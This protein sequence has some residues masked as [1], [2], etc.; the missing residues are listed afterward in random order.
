MRRT[1]TA[2]LGLSLLLAACGQQVSPQRPAPEKLGA[3]ALPDNLVSGATYRLINEKSNLALDVAGGGT[4]EGTNV[5]IWTQNNLAP[6]NWKVEDSGNGYATLKS[7][8]S[9]MCL[10]LSGS[11]NAAGTNVQQWGC[12]GTNAQKWKLVGVGNGYYKLLSAVNNNLALD[13]AGG[14]TAAGTNV[15]VWTDNGLYPQHWKFER[16]DARITVY[17]DGNYG[18]ASQSFG[19]GTYRADAGQLS[20]VGNDQI[21]S[22]KVPSGLQARVC[23]NEGDGSGS[24]TCQTF[25]A[26]DYASISADLNDQISFIQVSAASGGGSGGGTNGVSAKMA[27]AFV[28]TIGM[29]THFN[30]ADTLWGKDRKA[31]SDKLGA[32]GVR[33]IR[34]ANTCYDFVVNTYKDLKDRFGIRLLTG[35]TVTTDPEGRDWIGNLDPGNTARLN[36]R[37]GQVKGCLNDYV[38]A[39]QGPNERAQDPRAREFARVLHDAVKADAAL[40]S[41]TLIGADQSDNGH[42]SNLGDISAYVDA[43]NI[44]AYP[45]ENP[46]KYMD[47]DRDAARTS[48]GS[49][50][51]SG[52]WVTE[53]G[54]HNAVKN[55]CPSPCWGHYGN[56][57]RASAKYAPRLF[58]EW[59]NRGAARV[60]WYE[61]LDDAVETG[62][63][64]QEPHFGWLRSDYSEKPVYGAMKRLTALLSD[65]GAAFTPGKLDYTLSGDTAGVHQTLLQ[66]RDGRFYLVLWQEVRS[67]EGWQWGDPVGKAGYDVEPSA[68]SVTVKFARPV[69]GNRFLPTFEDG[70]KETYS[71]TQQ[72]TVQVPDHVV[73]LELK[74]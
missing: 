56:S 3:Q 30:Y 48:Y 74:P 55:Q 70:V 66:K 64:N 10:D 25:G 49:L 16:M 36:E 72:I 57:E 52:Y 26:G 34:D 1:I 68:K 61:F 51:N 21:S 29:N 9:G 63:T 45:V 50:M 38:E 6:Q 31:L 32:A 73:V 28:D 22:L 54:Y 43:A 20:T 41:K 69:S 59:F 24:G 67:Y 4:S 11:G 12:N 5:Q 18:G 42:W 7:Q 62:L 53:A 46:T 58:L 44:H 35:V 60:Y 19:V 71:A 8:V 23:Q 15:Q 13:V 37:L 17:Q 14:G 2:V 65:K 33:H 27:D 39:I 40:R 47:K